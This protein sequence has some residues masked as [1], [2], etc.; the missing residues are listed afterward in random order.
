MRGGS[1]L[2]VHRRRN[3]QSGTSSFA[4]W[5]DDE[6]GVPLPPFEGVVVGQIA[7]R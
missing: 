6:A 3:R 2:T 1:K 5:L 7:F 4:A